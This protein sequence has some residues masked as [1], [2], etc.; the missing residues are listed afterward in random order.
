[1]K[2]T[3]EIQVIKGVG[4]KSAQCFNK[5]NIYTIKDLIFYIPKGFSLYEEPVVPSAQMADM[6]ISISVYFNMNSFNSVKKGHLTYTHLTAVCNGKNV[7]LTLFN[8]PYLKKQLKPDIEYVIRGTLEVGSRG[9]FSM[10][11]PQIMT[12]D[13]YDELCGTLQPLYPLTKGLTSKAISKAVHQV[14]NCVEIPSDGLDEFVKDEATFF[15]A[16][17]S[18]HFP[19]DYDNFIA[20]RRRIVFHEFVNFL[21]Q[22]KSSTN[23]TRDIISD[24]EMIETADASRLIEALPYRLTDAQTRVWNE[25]K[26]DMTSGKCMN[27]MVQGDVGSGKTILAFLSLILNA[28]NNHQGALM[29]PT[30]VLAKQH[31][32]NLVKLKEQYSLNINPVLLLGSM[33]A[34]DRKYNYSLVESGETNVVI[35]THAIF[36][37]KVEYKDLKLVITDEQH[38]FG[39][40]QRETLAKKGSNVHLLVMSATPIPRSLAM[41][42]YGDVSL[43]V[44]DQM[45]SN[46]LPVKSCIITKSKRKTAFDF[47]NAELSKGH[48][49]YIICPAVEEGIDDNLENVVD[50]SSKI[51]AVFPS[52]INI[53]YM[54][55]KMSLEKK[56]MIMT[57]FKDHKIDILVSTTVIEVG[58]DVPNATV[59]AVENSE[60]FG[61]AQLHQIRGRVGRGDSQSYCIFITSKHDEKTSERLN[62]LVATNDGFKIADEDLRLRGPGD[63]FG[64]RQSGD[65]GFAIGDIYNDSN[66]LRDASILVDN[67]MKK[68]NVDQFMTVSAAMKD[69]SFNSVD[70][71]TI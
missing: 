25:I 7:Y 42:L 29:A 68:E 19:S 43:S 10:V 67:L 65:F 35:G 54:H 62:I 66:I 46:R 38:R 32:E 47:I 6:L 27:R 12:S 13:Q 18:I 2:I 40:K 22:M 59:I 45:P 60:R 52:N 14:I 34:K 49:A 9:A 63:L 50:Y 69:T 20:S 16:L 44:L 61:L 4:E 8:M 17:K 70:F 39:V 37:E 55:G 5:L 3:D 11:Q 64:I 30:E 48:Q 53:E 26:S 71:R 15:E 57:D 31:F 58:I 33:S 23:S 36:Q 51:R 24:C 28:T 21:L 56:N 41:I 1:M